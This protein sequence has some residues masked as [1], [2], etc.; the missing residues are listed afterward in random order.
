MRR[1]CFTI[2]LPFMVFA[3]L[4][5]GTGALFGAPLSNEA[6]TASSDIAGTSA[7]HDISFDVVGAGDEVVLDYSA[8]GTGSTGGFNLSGVTIGGTSFTGFTGNPTAVSVDNVNKTLSFTGG[9]FAA[10][11]SL[12]I[13]SLDVINPTATSTTNDITIETKLIGASIDTGFVSNHAVTPAPLHHFGFAAVG[14][15]QTAGVNISVTVTAY[16][17]YNNV[18]DA[19]T[20]RFHG[21]GNTVDFSDYTGTIAPTTSN[22]FTNGVLTQN[23]T[24]T[25]A[26]T[27]DR[28]FAFDS[29]GGLGTGVE[30]GA[31]NAFNVNAGA[32]N[33][34]LL[35]TAADGGGVEFGDYTMTT[36]NTVTVYAAE[37]D[38]YDNYRGNYTTANWKITGTTD[39]LPV[40]A[41]SSKTFSPTVTSSNV[42]I[43]VDVDDDDISD[44]EDDSTGTITVNPGALSYVTAVTDLAGNA[45][46]GVPFS[47]LITAYDAENNV[48]TN[49]SGTK[50]VN[51]VH[52]AGNAPDGTPP[53]IPSDGA[54]TFYSGVATIG[55]FVLVNVEAGVTITA[56]VDP[57]GDNESDATP[58]ITV[59]PGSL[60]NFGVSIASPQTTGTAFTVVSTVTARDVYN[61]TI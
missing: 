2:F 42:V 39:T 37:Y 44:P 13:N 20:N 21:A 41:A 9:S 11:A 58:A 36:E 38:Q 3:I 10:S 40:G 56:T 22:T 52:T 32:F 45:T 54:R 19:G 8:Y 18:L 6:I 31:S 47:I 35:R 25:E 59:D 5:A 12:A 1:A 33:H 15:P 57:A 30:S 50:T 53:T 48:K 23:V 16:D 28:I 49:Y 14:S 4:F 29:A 7:T 60:K 24:V 27:N 34:V 61:N 46:A 43:W 26:G 17:Q 55:G 51:W